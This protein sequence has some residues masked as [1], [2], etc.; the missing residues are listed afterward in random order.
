M[1]AAPMR[2]RL[3]DG[4]Q[5]ST[6][7]CLG[8]EIVFHLYD[9]TKIQSAQMEAAVIVLN[10]VNPSKRKAQAAARAVRDTWGKED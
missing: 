3:A 7:L 6:Y 2:Y 9:L 4:H 1:A 8:D 5:T 10:T